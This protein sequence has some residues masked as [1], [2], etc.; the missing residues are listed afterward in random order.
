MAIY[1]PFGGL[2]IWTLS[3]LAATPSTTLL[4]GATSPY[5]T[6]VGPRIGLRRHVRREETGLALSFGG[7]LAAS[8]DPRDR[9][10]ATA[11][12]AIGAQWRRESGFGFALETSLAVTLDH[13]TIGHTVAIG[14]GRR[15]TDRR[16]VPWLVP[17]ITA[18]LSVREHRRV[19]AYFGITGGQELGF[20]RNGATVAQVDVGWTFDLGG[21]R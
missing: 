21:D 12:A 13:E 6:G 10:S 9:R 17:R 8:V 20:G 4:V 2:V 3:A 1:R 18:R 14:S 19:G 11:A 7:D 16:W 15:T 5:L